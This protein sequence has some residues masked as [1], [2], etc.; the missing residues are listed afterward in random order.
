MM[1]RPTYS[2]PQPLSAFIADVLSPIEQDRFRSLVGQYGVQENDVGIFEG[3]SPKDE[4]EWRNLRRAV[5]ERVKA[6]LPDSGLAVF[7]WS[8]GGT[9]REPIWVFGNQLWDAEFHA[10]ANEILVDG[11]RYRSCI[12]VPEDM[13]S[14]DD[15]G[16]Y[17]A[18]DIPLS[19]SD[20]A[21]HWVRLANAVAV[22]PRLNNIDGRVSNREKLPGL[23]P[24]SPGRP[25]KDNLDKAV[26]RAIALHQ[27]GGS[28]NEAAEK[29][30]DEFGANPSSV[31]RGL[32][33]SGNRTKSN[34]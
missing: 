34:S 5:N 31:R 26:K 19:L 2:I 18:N 32:Q 25:R 7:G 6:R 15:H 4:E 13:V 27:E 29:A 20:H 30:A 28:K 33:P 16:I 1:F 14:F 9:D 23:S 21:P 17:F 10:A 22:Y 8:E 12:I 3:F 11:Q 24:G